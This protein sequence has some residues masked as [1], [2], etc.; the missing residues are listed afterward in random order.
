MDMF[1]C[2]TLKMTDLKEKKRKERKMRVL[3]QKASKTV[4]RMYCKERK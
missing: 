4:N 2:M 3:D 1:K